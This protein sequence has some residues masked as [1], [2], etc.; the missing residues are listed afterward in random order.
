MKHKLLIA[1][2]VLVVAA[3]VVYFGADFFLGSVVAR[4]VNRFGPRITQTKVTL[5]GAHIS[6]LSG[7]GT[8]TGLFV[9][10][11]RGW[12]SEKAFYFGKVHIEV[13]PGSL[14]G[15]HIVV[16][17]VLIDKPEFV[18]ET[19][20]VSSNIGDLLQNIRGTARGSQAEQAATKSGKPIKFE[21]H[22]FHVTNGRVTLGVGPA[23]VTFPMPPV[24]LTDVGKS[25]GGFTSGELAVAIMHSLS[26]SVVQ[27]STQAAG[28]IGST[29]GA[30]AG[31]GLKDL[32]GGK[33]EGN[34]GK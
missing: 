7:S 19:R 12:A 1:G 14:F 26:G 11:P 22:H 13:A 30:A 25:E 6:P 23:A 8:L 9:G 28:K 16:N 4:G 3:L 5:A 17:E 15:D 18:Y 34:S 24:E 10:N 33:Q 29:L 20:V 21:I 31:H 27:A 32:F 2:V